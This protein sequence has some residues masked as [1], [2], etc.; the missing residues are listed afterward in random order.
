MGQLSKKMSIS[1]KELQKKMLFLRDI[2]IQRLEKGW[3]RQLKI[4]DMPVTVGVDVN[5]ESVH[6]SGPKKWS[7]L[8]QM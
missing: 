3:R 7:K 4:K 6:L 5:G 2:M 8:K 1:H